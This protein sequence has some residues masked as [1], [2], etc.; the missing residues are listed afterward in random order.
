MGGFKTSTVKPEDY[1]GLTI[2]QATKLSRDN[3][4]EQRIVKEDDVDYIVTHDLNPNRASLTVKNNI[5]ESVT[6]S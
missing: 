2:D 5:V 1:I 4:M 3:D 6:F